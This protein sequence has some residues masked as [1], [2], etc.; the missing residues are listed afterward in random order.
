MVISG[1]IFRQKTERS[2]W[3]L[4]P[5]LKYKTRNEQQQGQKKCLPY[6]KTLRPQDAGFT[7]FKPWTISYDWFLST[8]KK[9]VSNFEMELGQRSTSVP[10]YSFKLIISEFRCN[11]L[12]C[13]SK[14]KKKEKERKKRKEKLE[15]CLI[16]FFKHLSG[17]E[18]RILSLLLRILVVLTHRSYRQ[19]K[20]DRDL[21]QK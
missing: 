11:P 20:I 17:H 18:L 16:G 8:K 15:S 7:G 13:T 10:Q 1:R 5:M 4:Q 6:K 21:S 2:Y 3:L 19:H 9:K 14:K 12:V